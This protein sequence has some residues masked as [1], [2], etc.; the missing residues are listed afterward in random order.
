[1]GVANLYFT[2]GSSIRPLVTTAPPNRSSE[3][4]GHAF[5][6][7]ENQHFTLGLL[8]AGANIGSENGEPFSHILFEANDALTAA[9]A[10]AP[11]AVD[12][13]ELENNLYEWFDGRL[14]LVNILPD[15]V[16]HPNASFGVEH[17]DEYIRAGGVPS[18]SHVISADGS[19]IF[20][21]DENTGDLY[22]RED[23]E[24][25]AQVDAAVGG[26]GAFQTASVDGSKVLFTK[27]QRLYQYDTASRTTSELADGG[28]QGIVGASADDSYV[29]FVDTHILG[30]TGNPT[31]NKPNL[32]LAHEGK[33]LFIATLS[34]ADDETPVLYG[35]NHDYG[36]WVQTFAGR[37]AEVSPD[38]RYLAFMSIKP[39]TGYDNN[40]ED[41]SFPRYE[42]F[43]YDASTGGLACASCNVDGTRPTSNTLLPAPIG[44]VYQQRYMDDNGRLFFSTEDGVVPQDK[45]GHMDLYEYEDGSVY[46]ISPGTA[47]G[48]AVFADASES[49]N[50]VFFTT[51]QPLFP[52]QQGEITALYD[53]RVGGP[54][55][56]PPPPPPHCSSEGCRAGPD[57]PPSFVPPP[58]VLFT[59]TGNIVSPTPTANSTVRKSAPLTRGQKL[60]QALK[61]CRREREKVRNVCIKEVRR[62]YG[63]GAGKH[64]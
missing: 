54:Q 6:R 28:V 36:D 35:D 61:A 44:G 53:A 1:M 7:N 33:L 31:A 27:E 23:G 14:R 16:T 5:S 48:E 51:E 39:L 64:K 52:G 59:G 17:G 40:L 3:S 4:F 24:T 20:W 49:G 12:G 63:S 30:Q 55:E 45:N 9:T 21:T 8:F 43:V 42:A 32:Y 46:L 56:P 11:A 57:A 38:G 2:Q 13:G 58:S 47:N 15:G 41:G 34:R 18:L 50:D 29:Y 10:V 60:T 37:T 19:R 62:K 22:V 26:G 25:T